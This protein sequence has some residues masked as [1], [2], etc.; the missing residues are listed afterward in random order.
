MRSEKDGI[1]LLAKLELFDKW[2]LQVKYSL[3]TLHNL[4]VPFL[5]VATFLKV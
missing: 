3:I 2:M 4:I 5:L 1:G